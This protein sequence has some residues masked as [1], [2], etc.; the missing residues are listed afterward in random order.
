MPT[1]S[2]RRLPWPWDVRLALT[3]PGP[4]G[5]RVGDFRTHTIGSLRGTL[6][7][8]LR[9]R[10]KAFGLTKGFMLLPQSD[11]SLM[12]SKKQTNLDSLYPP[13]AE[14]DSAPVYRERTFMFRPTAGLGEST[15][16]SATDRRYHYG[17]NVWV[18]GGLFGMGPRSHS[19]LPSVPPNGMVRKFI[20]ALVGGTL[21]LL[22]LAGNTVYVRNDDT[23]AGQAV[24]HQRVGHIALDA[25]RFQGAYAGAPDALYVTWDDG[26]VEEFN[27]TAWTPCVLPA[28]FDGNFLEVIGDELWL[29]DSNRSI[30]RKCTADPK[31]AGS[32][33]GPIQIGNPSTNITAIRQTSSRL[34]ILKDDGGI[35]TVNT[36]GSDNDLFPGTRTTPDPENGRTA[37]A[38]LDSLWFRTGRAFWK[39]DLT[40]GAVLTPAGPG[41]NLSN[42]SEVQGPVQAWCGWNTQM[43]FASIYNQRL[44]HSYLLSYGNWIAQSELTDT[45]STVSGSRY[46]FADQYD[47]AVVRWKNRRVTSM[48]VSNV[49][50][51]A[52][53]YVGFA[54]GGYD[55]IL[56]TPYPLVPGST[57][58][59]PEYTQDESYLV[60]PLHHAMFQAD[61]KH[62]PGVSIF[63]PMFHPGEQ[64]W[65][66]YRLKGSSVGSSQQ[67][68]TGD[69]LPFGVQPMTHNGQRVDADHEH[70]IGGQA[71]EIK[72]EFIGSGSNNTTPVLEGIGLHERLVPR[73]RR[74]YTLIANANEFIARRDGA[75]T[76]QSGVQIRKI[77]EDAAAAPGSISLILPDERI[78]DCAIFSYEEHQV[79][80][81]SRGGL[82]WAI[83]MQATQF[84]TNDVYGIIGRLRGTLIGDLRG[85]PITELRYM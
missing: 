75:S 55:W 27:G 37:W 18:T 63:G 4:P 43:A 61:N 35:F 20:E 1:L 7:G 80:H 38:W 25:A 78:N 49:P 34:V 74:D 9:P 71:I 13:T 31:V 15:Q 77:L 48:F 40:S 52:R 53:L 21:K 56:L 47:G 28:G 39:L 84:T 14:Y 8:N 60:M 82:G 46:T 81:A 16:A 17:I 65:I 33:G 54:D 12:V 30:I 5:G 64:V 58:P 66:R 10:G 59:L 32:W 68:V 6:I 50:S 45:N 72:I 23:N 51:E 44:G 67:P 42:I 70:Q 73:F 26:V 57:P 79:G 29:A 62:W 76:R 2:S 83:T 85:V 3:R 19:I 36:D 41:R 24:H 22:F 69:F 11:S